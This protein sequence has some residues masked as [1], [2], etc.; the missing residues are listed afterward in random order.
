M[1]ATGLLGC[2]Q[3]TMD[4]MSFIIESRAGSQ[5]SD[6][7]GL[8][9]PVFLLMSADITSCRIEHYVTS[10]HLGLSEHEGS[11]PCQDGLGCAQSVSRSGLRS[12][13][14]PTAYPVNTKMTVFVCPL[15]RLLT[16]LYKS[17]PGLP[18]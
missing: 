13:H 10:A 3:K 9:H 4:T 12:P 1:T 6:E 11:A 7:K 16:S 18:R 8:K 5:H 17:F 14:V 15:H 2:A